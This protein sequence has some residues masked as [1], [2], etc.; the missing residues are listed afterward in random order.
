MAMGGGG[1]GWGGV[2][3]RSGMIGTTRH[4]SDDE[5]AKREARRVRFAG[6]DARSADA[7]RKAA[8]ATPRVTVVGR[9][10][11]GDHAAAAAGTT[12]R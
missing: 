7:T 12:C 6:M 3:A 1:G 8:P 5:A 9:C 4:V 11:E 10:Y 2:T